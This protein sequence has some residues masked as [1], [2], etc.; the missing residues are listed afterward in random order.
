V[1]LSLEAL[2]ALS[3][4]FIKLTYFLFYWPIFCPLRWARIAIWIGAVA[5]AV[6]HLACFI[7]QLAYAIPRPG[8]NLVTHATGKLYKHALGLQVPTGA[9]AVVFDL[10]ILILPLWGVWTLKL[11]LRQKFGVSIVFLTGIM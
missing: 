7:L 3:L 4:G 8:E 9:L 11:N 6:F 10:Y 5:T 1:Q 2:G